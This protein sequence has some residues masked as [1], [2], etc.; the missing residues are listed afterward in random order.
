M[1]Q[2]TAESQKQMEL[3]QRKAELD[4]RLRTAKASLFN[5]TV[6]KK[7]FYDDNQLALFVPHATQASF[8]EKA[9][10]IRRGIFSG[11]RWGKSTA[12]VV[13]DCCWALGYRPFYDKG[14]PRRTAGIPTHGVKILVIAEDWDKVKEVFTDKGQGGDRK[15]KFF[16]FL[17]AWSIAKTHTNQQGT[18]DIIYVESEL[19]GQ[20]R[21]SAIYFDTVKSFKNNG[22]AHESS[23]WDAIHLDEPVPEALWKAASRGL[24][25]RN[26]ASWWLMTPLKEPWM[27]YYM[28]DNQMDDPKNYWCYTG[29]MDENPTLSQ[30][31]KDMYLKGLTQEEI[32][33]RKEGKP[34]SFGS[35]VYGTY[36]EKIHLFKGTPKGWKDPFTPPADYLCAYAIDPHGQTPMTVLFVAIS[37]EMPDGKR[38][39]FWYDEI[40]SKMK[41]S[42][43]AEAIKVRTK[44]VRIHYELCDPCAWIEDPESGRSWSDILWDNGLHVDK[45]SKG[46]TAGIIETRDHFQEDDLKVHVMEHMTRFRYEIK[47]YTYG[48]ENKPVDKDDHIMECMY[49]LVVHDGLR[50][51]KPYIPSRSSEGSGYDDTSIDLYDESDQSFNTVI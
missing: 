24:I 21:R 46:K 44:K 7:D 36:N 3:D 23:D 9:T 39:V 5:L 17:P 29:D 20:I 51:H 19:N 6:K 50:Y 13:E 42:T 1:I 30:G 14:D 37:P 47:L 43:L 16:D 48:K 34:L 2:Q 28:E 22:A 31:A 26:G 40:F 18:I 12:G 33:C 8:F 32:E 25:D 27:F 41:L 49:R 10:T 38:H 45:A 15:G 35:L 11:N 4:E